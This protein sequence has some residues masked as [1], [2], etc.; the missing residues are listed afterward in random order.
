M[1]QKKICRT[2]GPS[3]S[4]SLEPLAHRRIETSLNLFYREEATGDVL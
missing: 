1:L 4:I 3:L 2:V